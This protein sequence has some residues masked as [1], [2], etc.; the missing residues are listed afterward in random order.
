MHPA[1]TDRCQSPSALPGGWFWAAPS[2]GVGG[3]HGAALPGGPRPGCPP[4]LAA[5]RAHSA[6]PASQANPSLTVTD[7]KAH[8]D[9]RYQVDKGKK[10]VTI[11]N[12]TTVK[13]GAESTAR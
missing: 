3:C 8:G 1:T 9:S 5:C 10:T 2:S 7:G 6:R 12:S 13:S 4:S 11:E